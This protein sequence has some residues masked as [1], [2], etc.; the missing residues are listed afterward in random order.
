MKRRPAPHP[1]VPPPTAPRATGPWPAWSDWLR[2]SEPFLFPLLLLLAA[3]ALMWAKLPTAAE[4]AYITFRYARNFAV[5]NG[6]IYN[7]G[8]RVMGFT[9]PL[10]TLWSALGWRLF[11]SPVE[12]ARVWAIAGDVVTMALGAALLRRHCGRPAAWCFAWFFAA[13]PF[14][15]AVAISGMDTGIMLTLMMIAAALVESGSGLSGP[16]LAAL[17]LVR[18][19][20]VAAAAVIALG[21][22]WRDRA[23]ALVL[24]GLGVA[25]LW[26]YFGS[27]I[28]QS[29]LA[30]AGIYGHPGPIAGRFWWDWLI[31]FPVTGAPRITEG[32]HLF[33]LSALMAPAAVMGVPV[34]WRVRRSAVGLVTGAALLIWLGYALLGVAYFF[35][36]LV[37]P[38]AGVA[39]LAAAGFPRVVK[40]PAIYVSAALFVVGVWGIALKLYAGRSKLER[41]TFGSVANFLS[42]HARPGEK[43]LLEPIGLIG[44]QTPLVV[45]DEVGLV[46]PAVARRRVQGPGWYTD[47]IAAERP[48]WL[49]VR[50]GL[51]TRGAAFAG[52]YAPLRDAAELDSLNARYEVETTVTPSAGDQALLVLRRRR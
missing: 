43:V 50:R 5:G 35:W 3:R 38:L 33:L 51:M 34:L 16:A 37:V 48:D 8:E 44:Y 20:G 42:T 41:G 18:P 46:S 13:W 39:L 17:V 36:Y 19:E 23:V 14:F 4:D 1:T 6:L 49:V 47:V 26:V 45:V 24:A 32:I 10:W 27:P 12:W 21:A 7:P 9:S 22:R 28:P 11:G 2:P 31:P 30:K 25:S 29:V 15:A 40:G 52:R